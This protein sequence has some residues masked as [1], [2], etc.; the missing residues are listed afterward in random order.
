MTLELEVDHNVTYIKGRLHGEL[1]KGL[2]KELGYLPEDSFWMKKNN[3]KSSKQAWKKEWDGIITAVCWNRKYCKCHVKK[4]GMHFH[5]GLISKACAYFR[6]NNVDYH[7]TDIRQHFEKTDRYSMSDEFEYRDY[8]QDIIKVVAGDKDIKGVDRGIIKVATGGG[9]TSIA[10]AVIANIG[11][12]PTIFYVTSIDLLNQAKDEIERFV[13]ENG[14][15]VEVGMVGGG[16][17][18]IKDITVMTVQTA[19]RALGGVWIKYDDE[20][21]EKDDTDIEDMREEIKNLIHNCKLM[22]C[23]EVQHWAAETCQIIS[24][25]SILCQYRYGFSATPWRDKGDDILIDGCFGKCLADINASHLIRKGYLVKPNIYFWTISN[26]RGIG[27]VPYQ[28]LYKSA[29]VDN[30]ERN[31]IIAD[32][33]EY[34]LEKKRK[35]LILVKQIEHGKILEEIIPGSTFLYGKT[36]KKKRKEHLALMRENKPRITIASVIFD[37]GIDCK[38]LD[39][40]IL[41]GGGKSPTRALQRIGRIL[42]LFEGKTDAIAVDFMDNCQYL[43]SHS[44][45]REKI[46]KSEDEFIIKRQK[47][48]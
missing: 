16:H 22:I 48:K 5:S 42:R 47:K 9:K 45:K 10:C 37:E 4:D 40:L 18:I 44:K 11:I 34:F 8:Q 7:I 20:N 2:K 28:T 36:S 14:E 46:Y 29:I 24:D 23:D 13:T 17:K 31:D 26:M 27:K 33:A 21:F 1:Y 32:L 25:A 15:P 39:T 38:P 6:N 35:I 19:V 43:Q 30:V 3:S 41:A 12:S